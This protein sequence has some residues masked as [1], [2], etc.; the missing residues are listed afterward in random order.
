[1]ARRA[2]LFRLFDLIFVSVLLCFNGQAE[3]PCLSPSNA[4]TGRPSSMTSPDRPPFPA[5]NGNDGNV[6]TYFET[7]A[8]VQPWWEL[9][10]GSD[11][12]H[13]ELVQIYCAPLAV[14]PA[15]VAFG[16]FILQQPGGQRQ[17]AELMSPNATGTLWYNVTSC[18]Q[19]TSGQR[20][21]SLIPDE[22][23]LGGRYLRVQRIDSASA[24]LALTEVNVTSLV[25]VNGACL[26]PYSPHQA[27]AGQHTVAIIIV[28]VILAAAVGYFVLR[29][30]RRKRSV[31]RYQ[32][33]I[34]L[35]TLM[36]GSQARSSTLTEPV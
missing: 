29:Y 18:S 12:D 30:F 16:V 27:A 15:E 35:T 28:A 23:V 22:H 9:D 21:V 2:F 1:M 33:V 14:M 26:E 19:A 5:S 17:P 32:R 4:S 36:E 3:K 20:V 13:V 8:A 24:P 31:R 34:E 11:G 25:H 6:S 10:M 7:A